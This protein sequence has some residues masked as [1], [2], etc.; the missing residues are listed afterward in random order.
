LKRKHVG[1]GGSIPRSHRNLR[2]A[3]IKRALQVSANLLARTKVPEGGNF[4]TR[5]M[6][7]QNYFLK[8]ECR[9][10]QDKVCKTALSVNNLFYWFPE[11][12]IGS[13]F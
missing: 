7:T 3:R 2:R 11:H 5:F 4:D 6:T 13:K 1:T 8:Y 9:R 10:L 12:K